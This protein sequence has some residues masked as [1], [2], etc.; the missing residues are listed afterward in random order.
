MNKLMNQPNIHQESAEELRTLHDV[1]RAC[2]FS[3]EKIG[4][5]ISSC[6]ELF[7]HILIQKLPTCARLEW[8]KTI[9]NSRDIPV[10]NTFTFEF[11]YSSSSKHESKQFSQ[12]QSSKSMNTHTQKSSHRKENKLFHIS[13]KSVACPVCEQSHPLRKCF[14][15]LQLSVPERKSFVDKS[16]IC[17]N[18][19]GHQNNI[20]CSSTKLCIT[21]NGRHHTLLHL[22]KS[23]LSP[24]PKPSNGSMNTMSQ[25][26]NN[27]L[28]TTDS[29]I[30]F[31]AN[32]AVHAQSHSVFLAT[33]L[34]DILDI[35]GQLIRLRALIDQG[36]KHSVI[37]VRAAQRLRLP[38]ISICVGVRPMGETQYK[39]VNKGLIVNIHSIVDPNF[40]TEATC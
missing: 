24:I 39:I 28:F 32:N 23:N 35:N 29:N 30:Q 6:G 27:H 37:T 20:S 36:S 40:H 17:T 2:V 11:T 26:N 38:H 13:S 25:F 15:F 4:I 16:K 21:C 1:S 10:F 14:K 19:I 22:N 9:G 5:N 34:I 7:T 33:A 3:L 18:C 31:A 12:N 8:E